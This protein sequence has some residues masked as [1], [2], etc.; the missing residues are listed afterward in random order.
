MEIKRSLSDDE[1][2]EVIKKIENVLFQEND[3]VAVSADDL[4]ELTAAART[5]LQTKLLYADLISALT[6]KSPKDF[7]KRSVRGA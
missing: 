3:A 5:Y 6:G 1:L 2:L 4:Q 7:L